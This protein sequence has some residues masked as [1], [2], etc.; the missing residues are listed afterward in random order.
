MGLS[1]TE[2]IFSQ[3]CKFF[4]LR[5]AL[6]VKGDNYFQ[7]R[8]LFLGA[9]VIHLNLAWKEFTLILLRTDL[10]FTRMTSDME[11]STENMSTGSAMYEFSNRNL[12][13][14]FVQPYLIERC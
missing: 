4:P 14:S 11:E 10:P 9:V 2:R 5:V 13:F 12:I 6:F 3:R 7:I 1:L 8:V